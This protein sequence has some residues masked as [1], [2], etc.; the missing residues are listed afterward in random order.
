MKKNILIIVLLIVICC[1]GLEIYNHKEDNNSHNNENN[2]NNFEIGEELFSDEE[3]KV[4]F[5]ECMKILDLYEGGGIAALLEEYFNIDSEMVLLYKQNNGYTISNVKY[6]DF[7]K[8][9]LKYMSE[10]LFEK[11]FSNNI[12]KETDLL[13]YKEKGASGGRH[14]VVSIEK[15]SNSN[16]KF[17]GILNFVYEEDFEKQ[18]WKFEIEKSEEGKC[19]ISEIEFI[20]NVKENQI[21]NNRKY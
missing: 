21:D 19:V 12:K 18:K 16:N 11:T 13:Y 14:E 3:I 10:G 7:K 6:D 1:M 8:E 20:E 15:V 17:F 5:D 2:I 9:M 4:V